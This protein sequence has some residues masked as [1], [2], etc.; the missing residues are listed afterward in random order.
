MDEIKILNWNIGGA[1]Y[2]EDKKEEREHTKDKINKGL[3]RLIESHT[4]HVITL[5]EIVQHGEKKQG[6]KKILPK[7]IMDIIDIRK[8]NK[9]FEKKYQYCYHPFPLID[10]E[11]VSSMS[12]WEKVIEMGGWDK[13]GIDEETL[14]FAQGNAF[15][16]REDMAHFPVW[17]LPKSENDVRRV[18][19]DNHAIEKV[20][21]DTGLYF[22]DR[23][24]EPRAALVAHFILVPNKGLGKKPLDIFVVNTH[25]TTLIMEREGIPEI[26]KGASRLRLAQLDII[27]H[28]IVSRYNTWKQ[29]GY[30]VRGKNREPK[31]W[32]TFDR[33]Q[34]LW[35]LAGDFN[36]TP[37]STEYDIIKKMN[38]IDLIPIPK[39]GP[40]TK[41]KGVGK[42]PT[43]TLDY[44]FG[45]PKYIALDPF[46]TERQL[47]GNL[48]I[49][50]DEKVKASDHYPMIAKIPIIL[51][52]D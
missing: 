5:Q 33:Y 11:K 38:F 18:C 40:G 37:E 42:E 24:T 22:G 50:T 21:L 16:I 39:K 27:F 32:E 9:K 10:T 23:N 41:A 45:G 48:V 44:I 28:G 52:G 12:K 20:H 17:H 7:D 47:E 4:P 15:L 43:L 13:D 46:L 2:L 19:G 8:I 3:I 36:F 34:P 25:L 51:P 35:I 14:Y 1:K 29:S 31:A 26:D 49:N 30:L 6:N